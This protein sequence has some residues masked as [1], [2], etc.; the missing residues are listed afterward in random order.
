MDLRFCSLCAAALHPSKRPQGRREPTGTTN[1]DI[2]SLDE[3]IRFLNDEQVRATYG[4]VAELVGGIA[5]GIGARLGPRR[6]EAS[7]VVNA[8]SGVPTGYRVEE[9][10]PALLS[11]TD[12]ITSGSELDRRLMRWKGRH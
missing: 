7:W 1:V 3:I 4:A 5:Q 2:Y 9:R 6:A 10:H 12:I 11:K 8:E